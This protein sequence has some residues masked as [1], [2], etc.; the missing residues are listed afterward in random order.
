EFPDKVGVKIGFGQALAHIIEAGI[1]IFLMPSRYEPCGLNDKY[2]LK[3]GSV[4]IV[5]YTGG[6]ADS[7]ID[8]QKNPTEGTGFMFQKFEPGAFNQTI[9]N[10]LKLFQSKPTWKE[11]MKRGMQ[12]DFSWSKAAEKYIQVYNR[13]PA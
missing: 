7:V 8:Y 3:Y 1:D 5:H 6:L 9:L 10:A 13:N 11:M 4:P 2:S 12:I